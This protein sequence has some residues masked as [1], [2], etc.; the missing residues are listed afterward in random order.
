MKYTVILS[1]ADAKIKFLR[2][3]E[4]MCLFC[5][6]YWN[7]ERD[8]DFSSRMLFGYRQIK[9]SRKLLRVLF[10]LWNLRK[11]IGYQNKD[12]LFI[13]KL[14]YLTSKAC[15]IVF[16]MLESV[17]TL[18]DIIKVCK[19]TSKKLKI[20]RFF[21]W[22]AGLLLSNVYCF[23]YLIHSYGKEAH[24]K[25]VAINML[26]PIDIIKIMNNL[27]EE[28]HDLMLNIICNFLDFFIGSH[29]A[30]VIENFLKTRVTN[31]ILGVVGVS[32]TFLRVYAILKKHMKK[33]N[34]SEHH[35]L[36]DGV[37]YGYD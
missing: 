32:C 12:K 37:F 16:Y 8:R 9:Q 23:T 29:Y 14:F 6:D 24:L 27:A 25:D 17:T 26:R 21:A 34:Q 22:I 35:E 7:P 18:L 36:F 33:T 3:C 11:I 20:V 10:G 15:G 19:K 13:Q 31:G 5:E 4:Y 1:N 2:A 28:R 30:G